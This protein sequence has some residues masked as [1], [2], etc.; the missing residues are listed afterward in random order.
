MDTYLHHVYC[1]NMHCSTA[2]DMFVFGYLREFGYL[3]LELQKWFAKLHAALCQHS[4]K[5]KMS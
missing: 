1:I 3:P 4:G 5:E 2:S